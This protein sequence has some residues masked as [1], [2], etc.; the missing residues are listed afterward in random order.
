MEEIALLH[1]FQVLFDIF[2]FIQ[3]IAEGCYGESYDGSY[4]R[5]SLMKAVATMRYSSMGLLLCKCGQNVRTSSK[6]GSTV[7]FIVC[8]CVHAS[9]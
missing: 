8:V 5:R 4:E 1:V 3:L 7:C 2:D 6:A 9:I